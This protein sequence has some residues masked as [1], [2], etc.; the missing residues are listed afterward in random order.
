MEKAKL[1][2]EAEAAILLMR[3]ATEPTKDK[4]L[5]QAIFLGV[6]AITAELA[7]LREQLKLQ[8]PPYR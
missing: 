3:Q 8:G 5:Y 4:G 6:K 7:A 1:T 2:P